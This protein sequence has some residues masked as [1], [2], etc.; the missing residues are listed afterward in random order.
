MSIA[1]SPIPDV[2]LL[3]PRRYARDAGSLILIPLLPQKPPAKSLPNEIWIKIL[4]YVYAE[5]AEE[6][7]GP[8][9]SQALTVL[10]QS[11][12]VIC[13]ALKDVA[14]PLYYRHVQ[15]TTSCALERF[16]DL[17]LAADQRWD[18]IRRIPYSTPGRWVQV[19]DLTDLR[20][21]FWSDVCH[22]DELLTRLFPLLPFLKH[23]VLNDTLPLSR[24]VLTSMC[25]RDGNERLKS[26]RG[27]KLVSSAVD[28]DDPFLTLIHCCVNLEELGFTG[29]GIE[30][31]LI[32]SPTPSVD[33]GYVQPKP[34]HLPYL[35]RLSIVSMHSSPV[36]FALLHA[37]LPS[38]SHLTVTPYDDVTIGSSLV[39]TFIE[40]HGS[41]LRSLHL[42]APKSWPTMLF[43]SPTTLL[44]TCP[45]LY[46]ISLESPLPT[47]TIC[48][49][50]PKHPLQIISIP[51]PI[52]EF[53]SVLESLLPKLP[54]LRIVRARDVRWLRA[55]MSSH[56]MEAG[57]QGELR[58]WKQRLA[59]RGI[60]VVDAT[61][62]S[63]ADDIEIRRH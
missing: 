1:S 14:L 32:D 3:Q 59:R 34:L 42:Y 5:Y 62:S 9:R 8:S 4:W 56:A 7:Q 39:P 43:P 46:H 41:K 37:D 47:L 16:T 53:L 11:L 49:I 63:P 33:P 13:K 36:M 21:S 26:I 57:V 35:R 17:L 58:Q 44:H 2:V 30:T 27:V 55:G 40:K 28:F 12:L 19:L 48:S 31:L 29:S 38:L 15:F 20:C 51:R 22:T 18:S 50:Y 45:Q 52:P 23:L 61:W 60:K 24:R 54:N 10:R 6:G 25:T